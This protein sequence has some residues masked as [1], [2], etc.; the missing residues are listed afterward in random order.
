MASSRHPA[1]LGGR[2]QLEVEAGRGGMA[3]IY[4]ARDLATGARVAVKILRDETGLSGERFR[5]EAAMLAELRH[6]AI[7]KYVDHGVTP[8]GEQFLAMEWLDGE[9]L[10]RRL[11]RG[12]LGVTA[13]LRAG[14]RALEGLAYAH[15]RR[16]IHRDLKPSNLFLPGHSVDELKLLDF[17]IARWQGA[18][19]MTRTGSTLGTPT[20][21]S[22]EQARGSRAL[23]GRSD[24]FSLALMLIECLRGRPAIA[25]ESPVAAMVKICLEPLDVRALCPEAPRPLVDLL[26]WMLEKT[27][28]RRPPGAAALLG[29]LVRLEAEIE[30]T[31]APDQQER[32][33]PEITPRPALTMEQRVLTAIL[34]CPPDDG[35]HDGTVDDERYQAVEAVVEPMGARVD[36]FAGQTMLVIMLGQGT[37]VDQATR[38]A[39]CALRLQ[40]L[41]P[42]EVLVVTTGR[43][44][45]GDDL[46]TGEVVDRAALLLAEQ[47]GGAVVVDAA[48]AALLERRFEITSGTGAGRLLF[49][50]PEGPG[51]RSVTAAEAPCLGRERELTT[52]LAILDE[53]VTETVARAVIV[54]AGAGAGKSRVCRELLERARARG[55]EFTTLLARGDSIRAG[56]PLALLGSAL[57]AAAGIADT[58]LLA[59][60]RDR[61]R[62]MV[63]RRFDAAAAP[64]VAAFLGEIAHVPF[65]DDSLA[66][67]RSAR[68]DARVMADQ[69]RAAWL[70]WIEAECRAGPVLLVLE[71]LQWGD[72]S[73]VELVDAALRTLRDRPL[74]VVALARPEVNERFPGLWGERDLQRI[75]LTPL[76]AKPCQNLIHHLAPGLDP[77]KAAWIIQ[78]A[79]GNAFYLEELVRA[80]SAG[81]DSQALH[82]LPD[83]MLGTVQARFDA[84][85]RYVR[86]V[87]RAA[88]VFGET[89]GVEGVQALVEDA[90]SVTSA[91]EV[92]EAREIVVARPGAG[93]GRFAFRHALLRD[94]AY[95]MLTEDD[96][97]LAHARAGDFLESRGEREAMVLVEHFER[98]GDLVR[99]RRHC[100][101]AAAQALE[102]NDLKSVL[103]RVARGI[104]LGA[105]G[106]AR[107][108]L[109]VI[110]AQAR[111][112]RAEY[113]EDEAAARE[114]VALARGSLRLQ[115]VSELIAAVGQQGR[116]GEIEDIVNEAR[117]WPRE[118]A[119]LQGWCLVL[120]R[121]AGYLPHLGQWALTENL[122]AEVE[123]SATL[124]DPYLR[125]MLHNVRGMLTFDTCQFATGIQELRLAVAAFE[126]SGNTRS[127]LEA[128]ANLG[129]LIAGCGQLE[130]ADRELRD[131]LATANRLEMSYLEPALL[132]NLGTIRAE[133]GALADSQRLIEQALAASLR[134]G[135]ARVEA[136]CLQHLG[137]L[138]LRAG[139]FTAAEALAREADTIDVPSHRPGSLATLAF[140]LLRQGRTG[141]ALDQA[142]LAS[143]LL[144]R[145]GHG[146]D[147]ESLVRLALAECLLAAGGPAAARTAVDQ[148][149]R[150][151]LARAAQ[152]EPQWRQT[153][154]RATWDHRRTLELAEALGLAPA[155]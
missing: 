60:Q 69:L 73:T 121:A 55:T 91:L 46:P 139:D 100:E 129:A 66:A 16:V 126:E 153:F 80:V 152:V 47:Q 43:A 101:K 3:T 114:A 116:V 62:A 113:R 22:P 70:D 90:D 135:E 138:A 97:R 74:M 40:A 34:I 155:G 36:R 147:G 61:M 145:Q 103:D 106:E 87:L 92:L 18:G 77:A 151:L 154:L 35:A 50:R 6:P 111:L 142:R 41:L 95:A 119:H 23:D 13:T 29:E 67:L 32:P 52:L 4:L 48:T 146:G 63:A 44:M 96:R 137:I 20:Y 144:E 26:G 39:R 64:R 120:L 49:E 150:V 148:A 98:G 21:M 59:G 102:A 78:R 89:F 123:R 131:F 118:P 133:L 45:V 68:D 65:P 72:V 15:E 76:T 9:T 24:L 143:E 42:A 104:H 122:L 2:F 110:E 30:A 84:L 11:Q 8:A 125:G 71:D 136:A 54:T 57:R 51:P 109:R 82:Q 28:E 17:G 105:T 27:P 58:E 107:A 33:P 14:I 83:S 140:A 86:Q 128:R 37:P 124:T 94:A 81:L 19:R 127:A 141:D 7:V 115:A 117:G 5:Q 31:W 93:A 75:S 10:D 112:W 56:A 85:G 149:V 25:A 38:A 132:L 53:C 108:A 79:D 1:P 134:V 99:A 88:S 12:P 130:M